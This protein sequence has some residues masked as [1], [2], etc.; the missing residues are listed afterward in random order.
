MRLAALPAARQQAPSA[1]M[2]WSSWQVRGFKRRGAASGG[3]PASRHLPAGCRTVPARAN[4]HVCMCWH[5]PRVSVACLRHGCP[6][7]AEPA[8]HGAG[9][10]GLPAGGLQVHGSCRARRLQ[11]PVPGPAAAHLPAQGEPRGG[12]GG[13]CS[14]RRRLRVWLA[15]VLPAAHA[16]ACTARAAVGAWQWVLLHARWLTCACAARR[17]CA[18]RPKRRRPATGRLPSWMSRHGITPAWTPR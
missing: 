16:Q 17:A 4:T 3:H 8:D 9:G 18:C 15:R 14:C 6:C 10:R 1:A 5:H 7:R 13:A 11:L 12:E 2:I